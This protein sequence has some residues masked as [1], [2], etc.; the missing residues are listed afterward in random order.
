MTDAK[1]LDFIPYREAEERLCLF[2]QITAT[3]TSA[4]AQ[5]RGALS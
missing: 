1:P 3:L 2:L 4:P 5:S